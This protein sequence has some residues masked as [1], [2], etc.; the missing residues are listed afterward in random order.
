MYTNI[1]YVAGL[2]DKLTKAPIKVTMLGAD[3]VLFRDAD[4]TAQC[5]SNVCP[6]RG[7]SLADGTLYK[8]GTLA[9]PFHGWRFNGAGA[10]TLIP[11]RRDHEVDVLVPLALR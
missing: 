9:C 6:H 1:W 10:C 7:S 5:I 3:L 8:D 4:G 2:S 11:S